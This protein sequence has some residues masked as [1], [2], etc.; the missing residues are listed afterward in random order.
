[1]KTGKATKEERQAA[2]EMGNL[3]EVPEIDNRS[4]EEKEQEAEFLR[5]VTEGE[6]YRANQS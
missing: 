2:R 5:L 1:V 6:R 4:L 3:F